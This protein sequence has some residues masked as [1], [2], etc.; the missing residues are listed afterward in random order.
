MFVL[1]GALVTVFG[2]IGGAIPGTAGYARIEAGPKRVEELEETLQKL[3]N[4]STPDHNTIK[5]VSEAADKLRD[6]LRTDRQRQFREAAFLY[7]ILGAFF[8][9]MLARD[10]LQALATGAGWTAYLGAIGLKKD[11]AARKEMKDKVSEKLET[12]LGDSGPPPGFEDLH[13]EARIARAV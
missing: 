5:A 12:A 7:A 13:R 8:A 10:F 1:V 9:A 6:D 4:K 2:L 11:Y 3:V